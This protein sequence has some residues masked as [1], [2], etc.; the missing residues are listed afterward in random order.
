MVTGLKRLIV[1]IRDEIQKN[2]QGMVEVDP[3]EKA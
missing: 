3:D 1:I 2:I